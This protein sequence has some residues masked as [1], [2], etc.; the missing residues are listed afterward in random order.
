MSQFQTALIIALA[1]TS[2]A[3]ARTLDFVAQVSV[4]AHSYHPLKSKYRDLIALEPNETLPDY[5]VKNITGL[6]MRQSY[7]IGQ[8]L[9]RRYISE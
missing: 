8:E 5:E 3:S 9:R 7:L 6:G 4:H 1:S 2:F